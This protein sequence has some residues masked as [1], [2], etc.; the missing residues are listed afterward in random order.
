VIQY[1]WKFSDGFL[2]ASKNPWVSHGVVD[3][4]DF[5]VE[6]QVDLKHGVSCVL[7]KTF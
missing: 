7:T 1:N 4:G 2:E 6:L 3:T 5:V